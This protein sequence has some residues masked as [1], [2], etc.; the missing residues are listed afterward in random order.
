MISAYL[1]LIFSTIAVSINAPDKCGPLIQEQPD[2][3]M[4]TCNTIPKQS[5]VP[6]PYGIW[7]DHNLDT[8]YNRSSGLAPDFKDLCNVAAISLCFLLNIDVI[9][10]WQVARAPNCSTSMFIPPLQGAAIKKT[11][12]NCQQEIFEPMIDLLVANASRELVLDRASINVAR[13][14][15]PNTTS[16]GVRVNDGYPG[17]IVSV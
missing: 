1:T 15:F 16:L 9:Q 2:Q 13:G 14:A 7:L 10:G 3:P 6:A 8:S 4:D 17:Y 11:P 5:R 12:L